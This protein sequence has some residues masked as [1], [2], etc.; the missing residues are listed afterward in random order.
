MPSRERASS[1]AV[2]ETN[3]HAKCEIKVQEN[4]VMIPVEKRLVQYGLPLLFVICGPSLSLAGEMSSDRI[5]DNRNALEAQRAALADSI[6]KKQCPSGESK[7]QTTPEFK[8]ICGSACTGLPEA[9]IHDCDA[10]FFKCLNTYTEMLKTVAQ[11]NKFLNG[12]CSAAAKD[13]A[14]AEAAVE[15][16]ARAKE[17]DDN[18]KIRDL[19]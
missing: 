14:A 13:Q 16:K 19:R 7:P 5:N 10:A 8:S 2:V 6:S 4:S 12:N 15:A 17:I 18:N 3:G 9:A 11:Y 1:F